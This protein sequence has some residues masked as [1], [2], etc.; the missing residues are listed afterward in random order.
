MH[1]YDDIRQFNRWCEQLGPVRYHIYPQA[2]F[3]FLSS[4]KRRNCKC[5]FSQISQ[6][7]PLVQSLSF[8]PILNSIWEMPACNNQLTCATWLDLQQWHLGSLR[9]RYLS[10][11]HKIFPSPNIQTSLTHTP[12]QLLLHV[13]ACPLPWKPLLKQKDQSKVT[14]APPGSKTPKSLQ[15]LPIWGGWGSAYLIFVIFFTLALSEA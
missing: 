1:I 15:S 13:W 7:I 4:V 2:F 5:M 10:G 14:F 8:G 6:F 12:M 11:K 9:T 3:F